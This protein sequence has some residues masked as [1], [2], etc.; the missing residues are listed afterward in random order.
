MDSR[1]TPST[2]LCLEE[3]E[4]VSTVA[5]L[6]E[7]L[8]LDLYNP[9]PCSLSALSKRSRAGCRGSTEI[10]SM[11]SRKTWGHCS[12]R[13]VTYNTYFGEMSVVTMYYIIK[14]GEIN[15]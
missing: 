2:F 11:G 6:R 4:I 15:K 5:Q 13:E 8:L 1:Y 10:C 12:Q 14:E 7:F 9:I 3:V